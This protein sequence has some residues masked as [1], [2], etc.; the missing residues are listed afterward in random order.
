MTGE[1]VFHQA[2]RLLGYTNAQGEVDSGQEAGLFR[3]ATALVGQIYADL[4]AIETGEGGEPLTGLSQELPL[5]LRTQTDVMPYGVAMLIAQAEGDEEL[6]GYYAAVYNQ[7]R[8]AV[9]RREE[10]IEDVLPGRWLL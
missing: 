2:L 5:S 8:S 7:K 3:R 6:Q 9:P 4:S 1:A 10:R